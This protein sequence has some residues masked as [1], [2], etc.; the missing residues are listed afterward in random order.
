M[1][2]HVFAG[3]RSA[4]FLAEFILPT[5]SKGSWK[6]EARRRNGKL[7]VYVGGERV[8]DH[9]A[10]GAMIMGVASTTGEVRFD[11]LQWR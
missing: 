11:D 6:L 5:N 9:E 10:R 7:T 8:G 1:R 2:Q 3:A 4:I